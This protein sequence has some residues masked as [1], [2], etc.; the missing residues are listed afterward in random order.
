[1]SAPAPTET[2]TKTLRSDGLEA[3][4]RLLDAALVLFA[5]KGFAKTSTRE[6]AQAAQANIASIS[7]YF[8]DK[9]G[10]YRAVYEDPRNN[11]QIDHAQ[12]AHSD[13]QGIRSTIDFMLRG[14][15]EPLKAGEQA[16][17]CMKL[18]F[19]EM[20]EPTGMWRAEID[21]NIKPAHTALTQAL[22][23]HLG[24]AAP[25][26]DIHRLA[27]QIAG[28]GIMLHVGLDVIQA[29]RPVLIA[30]GDAL[31]TYHARLVDSGMALVEAEAMR[32]VHR[33]ATA[34]ATPFAPKKPKI[35]PPL[36]GKTAP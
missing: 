33:K 32:R 11:P 22:V 26:D 24:L 4:N 14:F 35:R 30:T 10:L 25:D 15:V 13:S 23:R 31:D 27:F 3:R 21:N 29:I 36:K 17:Q 16:R 19:R 7:Y 5:D 9:E 34:P 12:L 18:H 2:P 1:M 28:L 6:I 8:G 20:V